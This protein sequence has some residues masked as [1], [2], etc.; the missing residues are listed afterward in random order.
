[1]DSS[2]SVSETKTIES[3]QAFKL[4]PGIN[5]SLKWDFLG[6][7]SYI[8]MDIVVSIFYIPYILPC[9]YIKFKTFVHVS[10]AKLACHLQRPLQ[11]P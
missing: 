4:Y 5:Y 10:M 9:N 6:L 11:N 3:N 2:F 7:Y 8:D 1:M